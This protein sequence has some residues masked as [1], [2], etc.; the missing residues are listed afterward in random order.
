MGSSAPSSAP[1]YNASQVSADQTNS[2]INTA[3]SN[4]FLNNTNQVTPQGT[5]TYNQTG[6]TNVDGHEIPQF[7]A[8]QTLS[9][10]QQ[11]IYSKTTGLQSGALDTAKTQLGN[12]QH[13]LDTPF[14]VSKA[15]A[16]PTDQGAFR[17]QAYGDLMSRFNTDYG[18]TQAQL[19]TKLRNQGLQ[20]GTKAYDDQMMQLARTKTDA[21][22]QAQLQA[23]NLAGQNLQQ[24]QLL[25][26]ANLSDQQLQQSQPVQMLSALMGQGGGV[27]QPTYAPSN[28]SQIANTDISGNALAQYQGQMNAYNQQLQQQNSMMGGLFGL[29]GSAA[30][31]AGMFGMSKLLPMLAV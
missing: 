22:Q 17:D 9:P 6:T 2:N 10:E 15:P 7:T 29:G 18:N 28:N 4:K 16:L 13:A 26:N 19:D 23:G 3:V 31:G 20:P 14:D 8:T 30:Q 5:L 24:A 11:A 21:S 12:V 25:H 1:Q 27:T